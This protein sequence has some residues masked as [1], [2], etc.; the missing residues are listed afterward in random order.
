MAACLIAS[1]LPSCRVWAKPR[2]CGSSACSTASRV[3]EPGS[4]SSQ[5]ARR[6]SSSDQPAGH[7]R[8][9][10]SPAG[11]AARRSPAG[12][13]RGTGLR[14]GRRPRPGAA[15]QRPR[16]H[17]CR[18][19]GRPRPAAPG[20][21][22]R[23]CVAAAGNCRWWYWRPAPAAAVPLRWVAAGGQLTLQVGGVDQQGARRLQQCAAMPVQ[24]QT[25][26]DAVEQRGAEVCLQLLQAALLADCESAMA[27][28]AAVVLPWSA[29]ATK[30]CS[31]RKVRR[32]ALTFLMGRF[33][34]YYSFY[35]SAT[36]AH[37]CP[38]TPALPL[39]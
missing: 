37:A 6:S 24:R 1:V 23:R 4:R 16:R 22:V 14:S 29:M 19:A 8:Q 18:C 12:R 13:A 11:P 32:M 30:T 20:A 25:A 17:C 15:R 38:I 3:P 10:R 39:P 28:P 7:R 21:A 27:W 34:P 35:R 9:P 33:H 31:W 5:R 36:D 26:A 2:R